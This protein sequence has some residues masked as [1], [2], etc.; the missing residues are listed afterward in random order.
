MEAF[1]ARTVVMSPIALQNFRKKKFE[2]SEGASLE[3]LFLR[4]NLGETLA[5]RY[6]YFWN[7][8]GR[9]SHG[10][11]NLGKNPGS[12][13]MIVRVCDFPHPRSRIEL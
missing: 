5:K 8:G 13:A 7:P 10:S 1:S 2:I 11:K 6:R 4:R 12:Q 3:G 9:P